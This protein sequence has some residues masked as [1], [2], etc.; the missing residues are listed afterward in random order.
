L[1]D[2][3]ILGGITLKELNNLELEFLFGIEFD[4]TVKPDEYEIMVARL[5]Q[6]FACVS[7]L[8]ADRPQSPM[9]GARGRR[10]MK[11]DSLRGHQDMLEEHREGTLGA[12][13]EGCS[14]LPV[15]VR[16][17]EPEA[18]GPSSRCGTS[19]SPTGPQAACLESG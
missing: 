19:P 17:G 10:A 6:G 12:K 4:L 7:N 1:I 8:K 11:S 14:D 13:G 9:H 5:R 3:A 15:G 18:A 2:R 16:G